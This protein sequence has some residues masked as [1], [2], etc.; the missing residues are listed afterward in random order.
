MIFFF[1]TRSL[2]TS[3][4]ASRIMRTATIILA[5]FLLF[6][7]AAEAFTESPLVGI[8]SQ[9]CMSG[10]CGPHEGDPPN[11]SYIAASYAKFVEMA[12]GRAVPLVYNEDKAELLRRLRVVNLLLFPG[13]AASLEAHSP[14]FQSAKWMFD[15][16][17]K[18]N[19]AGDRFPIHGTCLGFEL[20]HVILAN[21]TAVLDSF[22]AGDAAAPLILTAH[23]AGSR[24]F[25]NA[26]SELLAAAQT[27]ALAM[28]S[29]VKGVNVSV[30]RDPALKLS[31]F[32]TVLSTSFDVHGKEYVSSVESALFPITATQWHPEKAPFEYN[33][34]QHIAHEP[35]A[36]L[37]AQAVANML[38]AEARRNHHAPAS[39]DDVNNMSIDRE[40][41][42][43]TAASS[44]FQQA[45]ILRPATR[46]R[47][48]GAVPVS[49]SQAKHRSLADEFAGRSHTARDT[50]RLGER[51]R[52]TQ[53]RTDS[54]GADGGGLRTDAESTGFADRRQTL[55]QR[56]A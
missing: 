31:E 48:G 30:Y 44:P 20:F 23:A 29:H 25:Q 22:D 6:S 50:G 12:G 24:M 11:T 40:S 55:G 16:A 39:P 32:F 45:Y 52:H 33:P 51:K 53:G 5:V 2:L 19:A 43:F 4:S 28:E 41:L 56:R 9:P 54:Q 7:R 8:V 38:V 27:R 47:S 1:N 49:L 18:M 21:G 46:S 37:L 17:V 13:G 14:F 15:E 3:P 26:S 35:A 36:I 42:R 34:A 10:V